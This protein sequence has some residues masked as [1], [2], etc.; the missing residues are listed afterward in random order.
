MTK[1][2]KHAHLTHTAP[3]TEPKRIGKYVLERAL[4]EGGNGVVYAGRDSMLGRPVALKLLHP[5]LTSDATI[6]GRFRAE[7]EAMARLNHPHVLTVHDFVGQGNEWA[8]VMEYVE[9]GE[10]LASLVEREGRLEGARA[11]PLLRGAARGLAHAHGHGIVHRDIKPANILVTQIGGEEVAKL[12]DFGIARVMDGD[13][14]TADNMTLGTLYYMS[15]EQA[16]DAAVDA[17]ADLYSFGITI[18]EVLTGRLP[19]EYDS[20]ARLIRAHLE[21]T[22]PRL[23][24]LVPGVPRP[25]DDLVA[26][27]LAKSPEARPPSADHI[28]DTLTGLTTAEMLAFAPTAA[29]MPSQPPLRDLQSTADHGTQSTERPVAGAASTTGGPASSLGVR[30]DE[31]RLALKIALGT[32]VF[33]MVV[34]LVSTFAYCLS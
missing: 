32:V 19:F 9:G 8:I 15:P 14:R 28:A 20:P 21:E 10:S 3:V 27:L 2:T 16:A 25:L 26:G 7:A 13:R 11:L 24:S 29:A 17:R 34:C 5:R 31:D 18:Y 23:S 4:G 12:T 30:T 6:L 22:A 33:F 1:V